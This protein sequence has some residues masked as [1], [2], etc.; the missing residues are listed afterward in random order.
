MLI[1][2]VT[3]VLLIKTVP[4]ERVIRDLLVTTLAV[5]LLGS[6]T[7]IG[8]YL[9]GKRLQ[10]GIPPLN[11]NEISMLLSLS[12]I[13]LVWLAL[14]GR[15]RALHGIVLVV[16]VAVIWATG[17]RTGLVALLVAIIT[18]LLTARRLK[19]WIAICIACLVPV[20]LYMAFGTSLL[21]GYFDRGGANVTTLN[22]RSIA[23]SAAFTYPDTAW[24]RWMGGGLSLKQ[25]P[26]A[27]QYWNQQTLDSS[28]ISAMVQA[29]LLGALTLLIW[30]GSALVS[31]FRTPPPAR[32]IFCGLLVFL[33]FRS[34][35]ESGLMDSTPAFIVFLVV[36][37]LADRRS[38]SGLFD[39]ASDGSSNLSDA[40]R[41]KP[42]QE[43]ASFP[44]AGGLPYQ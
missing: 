18:M 35:L 37:L 41:T 22:S 40:S 14:N 7:G 27:G 9:G 30:A 21:A 2:G 12:A 5:G 42:L 44:G 15:G 8:T 29:G 6:I 36:S 43:R 19:P 16:I 1:L 17:S 34:V 31:A 10:G 23:W 33:L 13:G 11:P 28:W 39:L 20:M 24:V 26:V 25:I 38:R 3:A 32:M 4:A